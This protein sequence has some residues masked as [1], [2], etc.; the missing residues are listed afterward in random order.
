MDLA[1]I[2][3]GVQNLR[4]VAKSMQS[5]RFAE[6][7]ALNIHFRGAWKSLSLQWNAQGLGTYA[8]LRTADRETV[9]LHEMTNP[10]LVHFTG[11]VS[12]SL[13]S[14][15]NPHVQPC[16]SKPW[17]YLKARGHPYAEEW[18]AALKK[19]SWVEWV[20][21][22]EYCAWHG[23]EKEKVKVQVLNEFDRVVGA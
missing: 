7:D 15:L 20:K 21:S 9:N 6:Q 8:G 18:W 4:D 3:R 13:P 23:S 22:E 14:V 19:T 2:R 17:G 11:P 5:S 16:A 1:K 10:I 12:P